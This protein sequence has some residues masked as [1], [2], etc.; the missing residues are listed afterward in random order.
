ML[1]HIV[2]CSFASES[3]GLYSVVNQTLRCLIEITHTVTVWSWI[4]Y[5]SDS[6]RCACQHFR[7][8]SSHKPLVCLVLFGVLFVVVFFPYSHLSIY[9]FFF[10]SYNNKRLGKGASFSQLCFLWTHQLSTLSEWKNPPTVALVSSQQLCLPAHKSQPVSILTWGGN[11][12]MS[13]CPCLR[14]CGPLVAP[15]GGRARFP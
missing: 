10:H 4:N 2:K 8:L 15:G 12:F 13:P 9:S 7:S 14:G 11:G 6:F 5:L 1:F 3:L